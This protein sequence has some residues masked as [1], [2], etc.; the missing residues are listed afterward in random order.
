[1][2]KKADK[3]SE[4]MVNNEHVTHLLLAAGLQTP[5]PLNP[6]P[7]NPLKWTLELKKRQFSLYKLLR[8]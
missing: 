4:Q 5:K 7:L 1:L 8:L 2:L 3:S 6:E